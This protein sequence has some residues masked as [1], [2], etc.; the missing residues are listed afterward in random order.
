LRPGHHWVCQFGDACDGT[1]CENEFKLQARKWEDY[2]GTRF[3]DVERALLIKRWLNRVDEDASGLTFED[4]DPTE[5]V[6]SSQVPVVMIINSSELKTAGFTL[7]EVFL[8]EREAAANRRS[9]CGAGI[10]QLEGMGPKR[11]ILSVDDDTEFRSR[12]E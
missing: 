1:S 4:W 11:F 5:N 6:D 9:T 3:Y 2:K 12:C 7:R 10:R 8:L